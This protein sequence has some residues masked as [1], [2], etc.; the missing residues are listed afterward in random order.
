M[1]GGKHI[2][3]DIPTIPAL[4]KGT[5]DWRGGIVQIGEKGG[6][7]VDLPKGSRVY[8]HDQSVQMARKSANRKLAAADLRV[9]NLEKKAAS[10]KG[11]GEITITI[12][13]LAEK[14][15]VRDEKDI[16]RIAERLAK[17]LRDTALN[18]GEA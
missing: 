16:D 1:V 8:P 2:G 7:I 4:A 18:M 13:K 9:A 14:I 17:K 15:I 5:P 12:P 3:F 11:K 10:K 6:E